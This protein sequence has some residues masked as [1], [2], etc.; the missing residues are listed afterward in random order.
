[1]PITRAQDPGGAIN[2]ASL[3]ELYAAAGSTRAGD[4]ARTR[5]TVHHHGELGAV[6]RA[7]GD[8]FKGPAQVKRD[9]SAA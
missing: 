5:Y 3:K 6:L 4:L 7:E 2:D 8:H 1:V 9:A